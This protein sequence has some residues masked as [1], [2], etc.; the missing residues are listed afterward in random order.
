MIKL[1]FLGKA[2]VMVAMIYL[3]IQ[4]KSS[5]IQPFIYFQFQQLS[6]LLLE[7]TLDYFDLVN[8]Q[9]SPSEVVI[10]FEEKNAIPEQ[11]SGRETRN[12]RFYDLVVVQDFPLCSK[13]L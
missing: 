7:S 2:I 6:P 10:Y 3:V 1:P 11:Y 4:M 8:M 9:E 12:K 13:K 5:E